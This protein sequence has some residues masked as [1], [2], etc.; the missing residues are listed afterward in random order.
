MTTHLTV[1]LA[2]HDSAWDGTICKK[3]VANCYCSGSH[4]LLSDRIAR[5][6][7]ASVEEKA[8]GERLDALMPDYLPPCYWSSCAFS[9]EPTEVVHVHPF[10]NYRETHRIP[11][12]LPGAAVFTWP[13]RLSLRHSKNGLKRDGK[14]P[15]D[16]NERVDRFLDRLTKQKSLVFFYLNYDNPVSADE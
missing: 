10:R 14:Y 1:R 5:D 16:W 8:R 7:Q 12:N 4:S 6:K 9:T 11:D 15:P 3:P 13:F 2:W